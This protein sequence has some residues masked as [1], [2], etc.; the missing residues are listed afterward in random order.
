LPTF[1][2]SARFNRDYAGLSEE[3]RGRFRDAVRKFVE[4]LKDGR[5]GRA[6]LGIRQIKSAPGVF[7]FHFEGDGRATFS[8]GEPIDPNE[9]HIEWRR[10]GTHDVYNAP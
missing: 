8:F 1:F 6:S 3:Q 2:R 9:P 10:V 7:E 5:P 4:D